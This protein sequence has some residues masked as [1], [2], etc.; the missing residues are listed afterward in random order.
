MSLRPMTKAD[1]PAV[2]AVSRACGLGSWSLDSYER[3]A[4]NP[5]ARYLVYETAGQVVG[6]A[7]IWCVA[8]EAQVMNVG[9]LPEYRGQGFA[10]KLMAAL[11]ETAVAE[12]CGVMTLE[13]RAGNAPAKALYQKQGFE[14]TGV[15]KDYY[16]GPE[17]GLMMERRRHE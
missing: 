7:G 8:D 2:Y 6:F 3:E 4:E 15:R 13:V 12:G 9:V 10:A 11:W 1:A 5:V 17:D 14:V 16:P